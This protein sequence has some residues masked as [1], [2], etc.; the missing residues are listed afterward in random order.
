MKVCTGE[1]EETPYTMSKYPNFLAVWIKLDH[2]LF[3]NS[4]LFFFLQKRGNLLIRGK[5]SYLFATVV[6][7][8]GHLIP[9]SGQIADAL[10]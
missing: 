3:P 1:K 10:S 8:K 4:F 2:I 9:C 6:S 7:L 5:L